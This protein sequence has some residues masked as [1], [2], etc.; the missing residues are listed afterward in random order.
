LRLYMINVPGLRIPPGLTDKGSIAQTFH[1]ALAE[2]ED[3]VKEIGWQPFS[4][5]RGFSPGENAVTVLSSIFVSPPTYS[6]GSTALEHM[7]TIAEVIGR[8][9]MSMWGHYTVLTT[10]FHPLIMLG[11]AVAKAIAKDGWTK[12]DIREYFYKNV[13]VTA[14][15]LEKHARDFNGIPLDLCAMAEE[16]RISKEYCESSDPQRL[17]PVFPGPEAIS[18][19]VSGDPGRNQSKA[20]VQ[21]GHIGQPTSRKI[22][23]PGNWQQLLREG[24]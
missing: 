7:E 15:V 1:V 11:P 22:A 5:D 20:Y 3:A 12:D 6:A 8:K 17:C 9:T 23:L 19:V 18:I 14:A 21:S 4:V 13:K 2:N 16:G 24:A 10:K